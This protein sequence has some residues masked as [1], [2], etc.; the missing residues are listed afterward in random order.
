MMPRSLAAA[1][2][3]VGLSL[4]GVRQAEAANEAA[5]CNAAKRMADDQHQF[6]EEAKGDKLDDGKWKGRGKSQNCVVEDQGD[7][8][9]KNFTCFFKPTGHQ[10]AVE[11]IAGF[12]KALGAC[13][14]DAPY[15]GGSH[16]GRRNAQVALEMLA[17]HR[18]PVVE[19]DTGGRQGRRLTFYTDTGEAAVQLGLRRDRIEGAFGDREARLQQ[20]HQLAVGVVERHR[21][22]ALART[23]LRFGY[24]WASHPA[25]SLA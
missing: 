5:M 22:A 12:E 6:F 23:E 1:A 15:N 7:E 19:R 3:L 9:D 10:N 17:R 11:F 13:L 20:V 21:R 25:A 14:S 24:R 4:V 16:L 18:I 2:F 8:G